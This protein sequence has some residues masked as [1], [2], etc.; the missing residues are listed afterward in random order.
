MISFVHQLMV[1]FQRTRE[2]DDCVLVLLFSESSRSLKE[3]D[4]DLGLLH[5]VLEHYLDDLWAGSRFQAGAPPVA[6]RRGDGS[7]I[8]F[9][10]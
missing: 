9:W 6:A 10:R 2:W 8:W 4:Y 3:D 7:E 1:I 5:S